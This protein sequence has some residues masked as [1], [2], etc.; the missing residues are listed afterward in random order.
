MG[1]TVARFPNGM[2]LDAPELFVERVLNIAWSL[3]DASA[4]KP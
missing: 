4:D 3:P 2:V 1:Y